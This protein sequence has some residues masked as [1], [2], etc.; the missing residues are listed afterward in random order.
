M[1]I[2]EAITLVHTRSD[3]PETPIKMNRV[4]LSNVPAAPQ[5]GQN[6]PTVTAVPG[7]RGGPMGGIKPVG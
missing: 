1:D 7:W 6:A 4:T 5:V 2:V 3:T